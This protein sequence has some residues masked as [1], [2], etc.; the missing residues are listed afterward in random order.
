MFSFE[1]T[2]LF[3][4]VDSKVFPFRKLPLPFKQLNQNVRGECKQLG[5]GG[6]GNA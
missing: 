1:V 3:D 6:P 2:P 4:I 5:T